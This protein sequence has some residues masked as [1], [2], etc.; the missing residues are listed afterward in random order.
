MRG[1]LG[2][3][4]ARVERF[5]STRAD[6]LILRWMRWVTF[7]AKFRGAV[8]QALAHDVLNT[9]KASA[10]SGMLMLFPALLVIATL[11]ALVPEGTTLVGELRSAFQQF[12]PTDTMLLVQVSM[13]TQRGDRCSSSFPPRAS[14]CLPGW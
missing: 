4:D 10:Y 13:Q 3:E 11:L 7:I 5:A 14:A 8:W 1:S 2:M 12:L 6:A 9:A